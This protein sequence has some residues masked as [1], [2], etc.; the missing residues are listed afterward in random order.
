M[1]SGNRSFLSTLGSC[2]SCHAEGTPSL[3][4]RRS[5][6]VRRIE[7]GSGEW[8]DAGAEGAAVGNEQDVRSAQCAVI[9]RYHRATGLDGLGS[10]TPEITN[11]LG[12]TRRSEA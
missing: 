10:G 11:P 7:R 8:V 5:S 12:L 3:S 6:S 9:S 4:V 2:A 1:P